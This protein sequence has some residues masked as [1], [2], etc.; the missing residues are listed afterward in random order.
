MENGR[1]I[2][3][4]LRGGAVSTV[5]RAGDT[6]RRQAGGPGSAARRI[7]LIRDAHRTELE[8]S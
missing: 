1:V 6:V 7:R 4:P 5:V 2:E 3:Y 8:G